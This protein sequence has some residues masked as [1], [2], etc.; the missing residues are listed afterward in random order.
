MSM[1][2]ATSHRDPSDDLC[3]PQCNTPLLPQAAF[4]ASCGERID[5]E[6]DLSSLLQGEQDITTLYRITSLVRRRPHVN[7]YFALDNQQ[8]RQGQQQMVAVR[9]IDIAPLEGEERLQAIEL[10]L[11]EYD[12]LRRWRLPNVIP[13][14][15]LQYFQGRLFVIAGYPP[16]ASTGESEITQAPAGNSH[17]LYTLQDFLQS[18]QGLPSEQQAIKWMSYL[19]QALEG[20]H[21]HQLVI[22][23]LDPYTIILNDNSDRGEPALMISWLPPQ[24]SQLLSLPEAPTTPMS[25][26]SA[27][28]ALQG[29]AEP[30]SDIYSLGAILY[31]L[32]TGSPP[33]DSTLRSRGRLR[34]SHEL[35]SRTSP[36]V[37]ECVLQALAIEPSERFQSAMA[38]AEALY[39]PLYRRPHTQK[40]NRRYNEASKTPAATDNDVERVHIAP[41]SQKHLARGQASRSPAVTQGQIPQRPH[42]PRPTSQPQEVEAIQAEWQQ[43]S[44]P[45]QAA[46]SPATPTIDAKEEGQASQ[47]RP[48][49]S[50]LPSP[51]PQISQRT[52]MATW[53]ERI[54]GVLPVIAFEWLKKDQSK[55]APAE[56]PVYTE[57]TDSQNEATTT[58]FKH[59]QR[60]ILSQQQHEVMAAAIIE[61]PLRVQ[62]NQVF[63]VRL[64]IM[65]RDEPMLP[66]DAEK[67]E[68]AAGLSGLLHGDTV[69]IEIRSVIHQSYAYLV[70]KA[71][72][73]IPEAGYVAEVTIPMQPLSS[74]PSGRRD[75]LHIFFL[76]EQRRPLYEKPF[77]VEV[78][79]SHL[80]KRGHEGHHVLAIP[81]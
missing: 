12:L 27:P 14:V 50:E 10:V 71:T 47:Q 34:A 49:L 3:C 80:V 59:L 21:S 72:V 15:D 26:F 31:L 62:P 65:G 35:N 25:Y 53:K 32:L 4:C 73:A 38:M 81:V 78:F 22:G 8:F 63:L 46:P 36:H 1:P 64:N 69:S 39:N 76:D 55:Q 24:L 44:I 54:T 5:K 42:A 61:S 41:L 66:L 43:P 74:A 6:K 11:Q 13:V 19:C 33:D 75:R 70:Q 56:S 23:E 16:S 29:K 17:R 9:D 45:F 40:L 51:A 68:Q 79:V 20:L 28:E 18:G 67:G 58:W 2:E 60:M 48:S 77:V 37:N 57:D 30:R 52:S 7:L